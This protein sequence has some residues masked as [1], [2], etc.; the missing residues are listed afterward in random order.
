MTTWPLEVTRSSTASP[1][2]TTMVL[3]PLCS[4]I[5]TR[6]QT[7]LPTLITLLAIT[8]FSATSTDRATAPLAMTRFLTMLSPV[9]SLPL[10]M[11]RSRVMTCPQTALPPSTTLSAPLRSLITLTDSATTLLATP[12]F[13]II[14]SPL[15]TP[16]LVMSRSRLMTGMGSALPTTTWQL[17]LWRC[18]ITLMAVKTQSWVQGQDQT[19]S[20]ASITLTSAPSLV[21]STQSETIRS[22]SATSRTGTGPG[23]YSASSV[24]SSITSSLLAAPLLKLL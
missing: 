23:P 15:Q 7:D 9:I 3:A 24:V 2:A 22:A 17:A 16:P 6:A 11:P 4:I 8:R 14:L 19:W 1:A 18:S 13:S 5:M 21:P 10:V 20:L 12:R